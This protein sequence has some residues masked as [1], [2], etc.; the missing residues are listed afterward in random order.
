MVVYDPTD[1]DPGAR[2]KGM[3]PDLGRTDGGGGLVSPDGYTWK[4]L[5]TAGNGIATSDEQNLSFDP[6]SGRFIY[7]VK[8]GNQYGR[9][10]ALVTTTVSPHRTCPT[11]VYVGLAYSVRLMAGSRSGFLPEELDGPG[12]TYSAKQF[13]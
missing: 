2:Y 3:T 1:K 12:G 8:R 11:R 13:S 9:A 7:T 10:V 6:A 4:Y 5:P